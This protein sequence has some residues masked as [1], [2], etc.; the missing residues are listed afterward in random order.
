MAQPET[1]PSSG[2]APPSAL[3]ARQSIL[4][5]KQDLYAYELLYREAGRTGAPDDGDAATS[6]TV[7]NT[8]LE[9]GLD[10]V[11]GPHK[12]FINIT[13][14]FITELPPIPVD[15]SQVVLEL[16]EDLVV[17]QELIDA[18]K[19]L[20][21]Q[22]YS[23]AIDDYTFE[24]QWDPI[25]PLVDIIKVDVMATGLD[26]L[27]D[28]MARTPP[29]EFRWLAEKVET[30]EEYDQLHDMGFDLFQGY[31]FARPRLL[32]GIRL[33]ENQ[34]V[35]MR[36]ISRL[37]DP[38]STV[39]ELEKLI[40]QDPSLSM[41]ILR[42]IN[43]AGTGLRSEVDSIRRAVVLL[44]LARIRAWATLFSLS[45]ISTKPQQLLSLGLVRANLC[46]GLSRASGLGTPD[47]AYT[48]GL[49][50]ILDAMMDLSMSEL[51]AQMPVP[52]AISDALLKRENEYGRTLA[53]AEAME[54]GGHDGSDPLGLAHS[55]ISQLY[56]DSIAQAEA[57]L[58]CVS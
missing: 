3:V 13:R 29:G 45:G 7:L 38:E 57:A 27:A 22:G 2:T 46:E 23:L 55:Q 10:K 35:M 17:D 44:G 48:V 12:A 21:S 32:E 1:S 34:M 9:I 20:R 51:M 30:Q 52:Q 43:S 40:S 56:L 31:F 36:L 14:R 24:P 50:S 5:R 37:N 8:F 53:L 49:L 58:Q 16:L 47:T 41:K 11:V 18:V 25:I 42:Y 54:R 33:H 26:G 28:K 19:K 39:E 4:T 6:R 15:K